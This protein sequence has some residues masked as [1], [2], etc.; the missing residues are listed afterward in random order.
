MNTINKKFG[1]QRHVIADTISPCLLG[2]SL[3]ICIKATN[4]PESIGGGLMNL[5][6]FLAE[7]IFDPK[8]PLFI[9]L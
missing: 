2:K 3:T 8:N 7:N 6:K 1:P 5:K 4:T 9:H